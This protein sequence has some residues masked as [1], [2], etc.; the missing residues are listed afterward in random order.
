LPNERFIAFD[1]MIE[2]MNPLAPSSAP[3]MMSTVLPMA[4]P[5]ALAARPAYELSSDTTT[6]MSAPP[7]G[8]TNDTPMTR[9]SAVIAQKAQVRSGLAMSST[10]STTAPAIAPTLTTFCPR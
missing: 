1:M 5:V 7:M 2:R 3:A 9:A 6:G 8:S 4:K 10:H